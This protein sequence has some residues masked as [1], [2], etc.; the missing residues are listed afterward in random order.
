MERRHQIWRDQGSFGGGGNLHDGTQSD[1][2]DRRGAS[3]IAARRPLVPAGERH[4][5]AQSIAAAKELSELARQYQEIEAQIRAARPRYAS[6]TQPQPLS[7]AEIQRQVLDA[8]TL[9]LEYALGPDHSYLWAVTPDSVS[10]YQLPPR[11]EIEAAARRVY[12][13]LTARQPRP[14]ETDAQRQARIKEADAAYPVEAA[15]LSRILLS[16][17]ASQ[18]GAKRLLVVAPGML[19]YLPFAVLPIPKVPNAKDREGGKTAFCGCIR[20]ITCGRRRSW[21]C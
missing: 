21:W 5:V 1:R 12:E 6:L 7:V 17:A 13:L 19:E 9:L 15:A 16:P 20:S 10:S 2:D 3:A 8:D 4:A 14:G 11:A 18:L